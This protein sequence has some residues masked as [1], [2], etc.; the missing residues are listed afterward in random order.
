[1]RAK[2]LFFILC[3]LLAI[4]LVA[5]GAAYFWGSNILLEQKQ[6]V[7][8][9]KLELDDS[10]KR[11]DQLI[12][13]S[14]RYDSA[15]AQAEEIDKALPRSSQQAEI[16]LELKSAAAEN[17]VTIASIQFT[18]QAT[19]A[20]AQTNQATAQQDYLILPISIRA[21]ATYPQLIAY[22]NRL[23]TLSRYNSVT[24]LSATKSQSNRDNLEISMSIV[25]Y[26]KP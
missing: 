25:A 19:P 4:L 12:Q 8:K 26:L 17:G 3:A 7:S 23:E 9:K 24:S 22:L 13:L 11:I 18:G 10:Q 14:R 16:L 2:L 6:E 1:V 21:S 20:K 5:S 15:K